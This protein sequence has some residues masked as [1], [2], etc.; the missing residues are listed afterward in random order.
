[1]S[2]PVALLT[3]IPVEQGRHTY[4]GS[5]QLLKLFEGESK[6]AH[7]SW[8]DILKRMKKQLN[9]RRKEE[10]GAEQSDSRNARVLKSPEL[11]DH[12]MFQSSTGMGDLKALGLRGGFPDAVRA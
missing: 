2:Q 5:K 6:E 11:F 8:K 10:Q 3:G 7:D 1:M 12:E 9:T 4:L